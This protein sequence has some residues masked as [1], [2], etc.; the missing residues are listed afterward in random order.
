VAIPTFAVCLFAAG[1]T[2]A[3]PTRDPWRTLSPGLDVAD[4]ASPLASSHGDSTITVVRLDPERFEL[5][6][7]SAKLL[8]LEHPLTAKE[9]VTRYGMTGAINA[10]MYD[11]DLMSSVAYMKGPEGVNNARW[12][13]DNAV[14]L[15]RPRR[16]G[17]PPV[18]I[19][20]RACEDPGSYDHDYDVVIQNIRMLDCEGHN[21]WTPQPRR[22]STAAVGVDGTGRVLLIHCRSPYSTHDFI[23]ILRGLPL[24]LERLMYVEGGPE[25][26]LYVAAEGQEPIA[27]IGS[28]ETGFREL[29]DNQDFWAI[30]NVI[31]FLPRN[32][33]AGSDK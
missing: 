4:L 11:K 28:F 22:W 33:H 8:K 21:T 12:T 25:A 16:A 15:A 32:A 19:A 18:R 9:W 6:L 27:R 17:L 2:A 10:S 29:D 23:D 31:A 26:S 7:L 24:H 30:P 13:K 5:R 20:D 1:L 3:A 14:F